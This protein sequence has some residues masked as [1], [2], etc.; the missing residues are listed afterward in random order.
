MRS[1]HERWRA[2]ERWQ[3]AAATWKGWNVCPALMAPD[4][5]HPEPEPPRPLG[6]GGV[7]ARAGHLVTHLSH[8]VRE[9]GVLL[10][11]DL[12]PVLGLCVAAR[13]NELRLANAVLVLPRWPYRVA[14]LPVDELIDRLIVESERLIPDQ[15]MPSVAFV[16]DSQRD[17]AIPDRSPDDPRA[18][19]RYR[20]SVGDL[21]DLRALRTRTIRH[22]L[23]LTQQ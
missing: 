21:P 6:E 5:R 14:V 12:E 4:P 10:L 17:C 9:G 11:L 13:L 3:A 23:K 15:P 16:L 7:E 2:W 18:D 20:L 19:N 8:E 22:V 1:A